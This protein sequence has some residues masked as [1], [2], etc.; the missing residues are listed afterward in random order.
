MTFLHKIYIYLHVLISLFVKRLLISFKF[1]LVRVRVL[2]GFIDYVFGSYFFHKDNI[3]DFKSPKFMKKEYY[4]K[5]LKKKNFL[6]KHSKIIKILNFN[7]TSINLN[8]F[9][10]KVIDD[11]ILKSLKKYFKKPQNKK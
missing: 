6:L 2:F 4:V 9:K 11:F 8:W 1:V 5:S 7:L 3:L 10:K